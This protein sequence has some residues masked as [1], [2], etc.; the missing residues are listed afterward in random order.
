MSFE[1]TRMKVYQI[2]QELSVEKD[3]TIFIHGQ[4]LDNRSIEVYKHYAKLT[5]SKYEIVYDEN[6]YEFTVNSFCLGKPKTEKIKNINFGRHFIARLT[7]RNFY[8]DATSLGF[9]ELLLIL[10]HIHQHFKNKT[11]KVIYAEPKEYK[12]KKEDNI[13]SDE[14]DLTTEFNDFKKIPPFSILIDSNSTSKAELVSFLG[15][16][17]DRLGR[18]IENDEGA[19][20]EK[21]TPVLALPAFVPGWE[22]ISLRR[23]HKE[24][25]YFDKIEFSPAN[26]P[27]ETYQKLEDIHNNSKS[28]TLVLAPIGTKPHAVGAIIYLIN[29]KEKNKHI[30]LIYDFPKKKEKRTDGIGLVHEYSLKILK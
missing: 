1:I 22:N 13:F 23:H 4:R 16:E 3:S 2:I 25:S 9:A 17:N 15:F 10:F 14:F 28:E 7:C 19:R 24:L 5:K 18:I 12:L 30:G 20:Y 21:Y 8:L 29:A 6:N 27:Y 26:N 11:I